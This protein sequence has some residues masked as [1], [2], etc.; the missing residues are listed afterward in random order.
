[1]HFLS[2][3]I[4]QCFKLFLFAGFVY[5]AKNVLLQIFLGNCFGKI[6]SN[7]FLPD[8]Y[9]NKR[10]VRFVYVRWK[11]RGNIWFADKKWNI[12][13]VQKTER[14]LFG[15]RFEEFCIHR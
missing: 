5:V 10:H 8:I 13:E 15:R 6:V 2:I 11:D 7:E 12:I 9:E 1:M 4:G 3:F 14:M